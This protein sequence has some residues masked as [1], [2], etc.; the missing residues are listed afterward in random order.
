MWG[1]GRASGDASGEQALVERKLE[2]ITKTE[3]NQRNNKVEE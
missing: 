1:S 2:G 3:R